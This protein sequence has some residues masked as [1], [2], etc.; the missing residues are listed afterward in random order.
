MDKLVANESEIL[1][2]R[3]SYFD[4]LLN[5]QPDDVGRGLKYYIAEFLV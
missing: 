3:K 4:K 1:Q 5:V 2:T